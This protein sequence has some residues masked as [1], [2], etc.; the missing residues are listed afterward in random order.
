METERWKKLEAIYHSAL[1]IEPIE[2]EEF[3]QNIC[4]DDTEMLSEVKALLAS[5]LTTQEILQDNAFDIGMKILEKNMSDTITDK[6]PTNVEDKTPNL[7]GGRYELFL[8]LGE[9]GMGE[10]YLASDTTLNRKVVVKFLQNN[11]TNNWIIEKFKDEAVVQS[12]ISHP[13][14]AVAFDKGVLEKERVTILEYKG[15]SEYR[16]L[17]KDSP[18]LVMEF[19]DGS[20]VSEIITQF[21]KDNEQIP[22]DLMAKIISQA[23]NGVDAI[24]QSKLVHRDL[25]PANLMM[26]KKGLLKVIDFGIARDLTKGTSLIP[27]GTPAYMPIE[28]LNRQ[29][30]SP[31]TDVFALGVIAYQLVTLRLPFVGNDGLSHIRSRQEGVKIL[32]HVLRPDLPKEAETLILQALEYDAAKRPSSAKEFGDKLAEILTRKPEQSPIIVKP[33]YFKPLFAVASVALLALAVL[34][35]WLWLGSGTKTVKADEIAVSRPESKPNS[36]KPS[37]TVPTTANAPQNSTSEKP[38]Y[39]A[40]SDFPIGKAANGSVLAQIGLTF[41]RSRPATSQ[42]SR[43]VAR[44][45]VDAQ[46]VVYESKDEFIKHGDTFRLSIEAMVED[47]LIDKSTNKF[48]SQKGGYVY[49]INR[50]QFSDG[51]FGRAT[52]IFPTLKTYDGKNLVKAG[53]PIILPRANGIPFEIRRSSNKQIAE[54][55]TIIISPWEFQLPATLSFEPMVL[56]DNLV[57]DWESKY[58]GKMYRATKR[59]GIGKPQT[60]REQQVVSR[61]TI[62][63]QEPLTQSDTRTFP[64]TA[65]RRAVKIGNPAMF[66]VALKFKD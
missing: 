9:G 2:R 49:V 36:N 16:K 63:T 56:P 66:T 21:Q 29:E 5:D 4:A 48:L 25:K 1:A 33:N 64:Q 23:G 3:L 59:N 54:T 60:I 46:E 45:T 42:D 51:T 32:P 41:W 19:I 50:E 57:A 35:G 31:A 27:V 40:E 22:F 62:D 8:P 65:Y 15:K 13:N 12:Q 6:F 47:F 17:A 11:T 55:Y 20:N 10:V 61:E 37:E 28:Q 26:S 18:Y 34:A 38:V 24:H 53:E 52:L 14:V 30:V 7:I 58:G 43:D 44:E 39:D